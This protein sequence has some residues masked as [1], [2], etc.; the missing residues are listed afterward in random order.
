[1]LD[2]TLTSNGAEVIFAWI[3]AIIGP[4]ISRVRLSDRGFSDLAH[5]I[6]P[7]GLALD[8]DGSTILVSSAVCIFQVFYRIDVATG[9][10]TLLPATVVSGTDFAI[11]PGGQEVVATSARPGGDP[12]GD[13]W[14]IVLSTGQ[15]TKISEIALAPWGVVSALSGTA[16]L[17]TTGDTVSRVVLATGDIA[18]L[19]SGLVSPTG[20]ALESSGH[21]AIVVLSSSEVARVDLTTKAVV[22]LPTTLNSARFVAVESGDQSV[23]VAEISKGLSRI[24][25][26]PRTVA[27]L[28]ADTTVSGK[29]VV[30]SGGDTAL[31]ATG[32]GIKRVRIR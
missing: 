32:E 16:A 31:L 25:R 19:A 14:R 2:F 12:R 6:V 5:G 26:A 15:T 23:L 9:V 7:S 18:V 1:M 28:L 30:E 13:L 11:L 20:I 17:I 4:R 27:E 3:D 22:K 10:A 21:A 29:V 8:E 24:D